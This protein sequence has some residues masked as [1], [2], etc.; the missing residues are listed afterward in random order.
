MKVIIGSTGCGWKVKNVYKRPF[1][2]FLRYF[3]LNCD[4][5]QFCFVKKDQKKQ[6]QGGNI[7]S[8]EM[9]FHERL[10]F[11]PFVTLSHL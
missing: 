3:T 9:R 10:T 6:W 1:I 7:L 11:A 5:L 8:L 4:T 2:L